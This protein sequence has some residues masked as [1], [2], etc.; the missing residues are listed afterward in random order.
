MSRPAPSTTV[1][2]T[3]LEVFIPAFQSIGMGIDIRYKSVDA[4]MAKNVQMTGLD[5][6]G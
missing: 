5:T 3:F 1:G 2:T 6:A 4:F